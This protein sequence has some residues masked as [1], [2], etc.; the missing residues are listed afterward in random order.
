MFHR[1]QSTREERMDKGK[2]NKKKCKAKGEEGRDKERDR[3][4]KKDK[5]HRKKENH[6]LL[7]TTFIDSVSIFSYLLFARLQYFRDNVHILFFQKR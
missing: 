2:Y 4:I 6:K 1:K 3:E 5:K 7:I